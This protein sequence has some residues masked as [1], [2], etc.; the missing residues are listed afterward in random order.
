M[1]VTL[2]ETTRCSSTWVKVIQSFLT[3]CDPMNCSPSCSSV[4]GILQARIVEWVAMPSSRGSCWPRDRTQVS[5]MYGNSLR[6]VLFFTPTSN[7]RVPISP[8][9]NKVCCQSDKEIISQCS[10]ILHFLSIVRGQASA[11]LFKDLCFPW[12]LFFC[13]FDFLIVF[14]AMQKFIIM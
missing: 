1:Y 4:H 5:C 7:M 8:H 11:R 2:L 14:S 6:F 9:Y 13:R 3:L 10:F 12:I